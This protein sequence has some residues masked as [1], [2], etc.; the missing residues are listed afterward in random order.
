MKD[1]Y[2]GLVVPLGEH[3]T[4]THDSKILA[5]GDVAQWQT[6]GNPVP[7]S[8]DLRFCNFVDLERE[9]LQVVSPEV[10]LTPVVADQF[11]C[12]DVAL[13]LDTLGYTGSLRALGNG[14]PKPEMIE[15]EIKSLCPTLDF[16]LVEI[17]AVARLS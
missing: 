10:I 5:V 1:R 3:G 6:S 9:F 11:D 7:A 8:A 2:S 12:A 15:R 16:A 17:E 13:R 4:R 14:M